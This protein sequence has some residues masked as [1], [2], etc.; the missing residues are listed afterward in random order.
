MLLIMFWIMTPLRKN[1][2][3]KISRVSVFINIQFIIFCI[4]LKYNIRIRIRLNMNNT[5]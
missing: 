2:V 3:L 1:R 5:K 4:Y